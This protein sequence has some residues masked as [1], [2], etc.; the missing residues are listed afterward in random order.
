MWE[1]LHNELSPLGVT[2][3]TVALDSDPELARPWIDAASPT[4]PSLIDRS[5]STG[6]LL[7][8]T[9]VPMA[10]WV[11]EEGNLVRPAEVANVT[12]NSMRGREIPEGLPERIRARLELVAEFP[13]EHELYLEAMRDWA[14][15]GADSPYALAPEDVIARSQP[16]GADEATA[17]A[18]FAMG[19]YLRDLDGPEAAVPYW[20][21]A[22]RLHPTNWTYK[23][24]AWS[25]ETTQPGQ[26]S[27]LIQEPTDRYEGNWL[28]DLIAQGGAET[29]Y[30][31][32]T[33]R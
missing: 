33:G 23:R 13:G 6:A 25:L 2:V 1:A 8:F 7:G 5:H 30:P 11:N 21:E 17:A 18:N 27:D 31:K 19:Q 32:F 4:H 10:I 3:V 26:P 28:D 9:N 22:H 16:R 20:R 15:N 14:T 29:Y 24:Q 12:P